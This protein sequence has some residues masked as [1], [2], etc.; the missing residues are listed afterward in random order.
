MSSQTHC[1]AYLR[2]DSKS[3]ALTNNIKYH[4]EENNRNWIEIK[5][6]MNPLR[7]H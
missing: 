1:E 2:G 5:Q 6:A 4:K 7:W 3:H